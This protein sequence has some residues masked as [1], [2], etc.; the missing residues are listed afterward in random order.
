MGLRDKLRRLERASR[1]ELVDMPQQDGTVARFPKS[2]YKEAF[3]NAVDRLGA[4]EA[5]PPR[6]PLL[7]A[8]ANS[9]DPVGGLA[10]S[11]TSTSTAR[12]SRSRT[13]PS[14]GEAERIRR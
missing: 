11:R 7:E 8:A 9:S 6:H 13:S 12:S 1:E 4:G 3:L 14:R 10:S 2:A 5:A